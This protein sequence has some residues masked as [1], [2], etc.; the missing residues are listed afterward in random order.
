MPV[1]WQNVILHPNRSENS[2]VPSTCSMVI[3]IS[4]E[5]KTRK[6]QMSNPPIV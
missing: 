3:K 5:K 2:T 4:A 1:G 6:N